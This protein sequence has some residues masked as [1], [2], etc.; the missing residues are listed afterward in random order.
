MNASLRIFRNTLMFCLV[1]L[2]VALAPAAHAADVT[3]TWLMAVKFGEINGTPTFTLTQHDDK[4][5]GTFKGQLG[6]ADVTGTVT[7]SA[8]KLSFKTQR[9]GQDLDVVYTGTVD[10]DNMSGKVEF[11]GAGEGTFTGKRK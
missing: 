10:G 6:E 4:V 9:Q 7:G 8:V 2:V 5:T 3:G 11:V 1:A